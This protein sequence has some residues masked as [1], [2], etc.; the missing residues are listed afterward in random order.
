MKKQR[1]EFHSA[2][3][4][5][6]VKKRA[7]GEK[8]AKLRHYMQKFD[9]VLK[10][11]NTRRC[12]AVRKAKDERQLTE[13]KQTQLCALRNKTKEL[14]QERQC[15]KRQL[16]KDTLNLTYLENVV[17]ASE[18][19]HEPQQLIHS[20]R[21]LM[22]DQENLL[23]IIQEKQDCS[24]NARAELA[25][26]T[27]QHVDILLRYNN[28]L[29]Q[30]QSKLEEILAERM[31]WESKWNHIQDTAAKKVMLIGTIKMAVFNVY[32]GLC[33]TSGHVEDSPTAPEDTIK[34]LEKIQSLFVSWMP[35]WESINSQN[36]L[37]TAHQ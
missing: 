12:R 13:Q 28:K 7:L 18:Q 31:I 10:E 17:Q 30:L 3:E 26:Q 4:N 1:E 11:H 37:W 9:N 32:Q 8:E 2:F 15:L 16:H 21:T 36:Q 34:L 23:C 6:Q 22:L 20:F 27:E 25:R 33:K 35:I 14:I 19:F 24:E 29:S 5:L